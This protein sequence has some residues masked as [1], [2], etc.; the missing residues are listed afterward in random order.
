MMHNLRIRQEHINS[1]TPPFGVKKMSSDMVD[2]LIIK[3]EI[4]IM[5]RRVLCKG[6]FEYKSTSGSCSCY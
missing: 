6:C 5:K 2:D 3:E 1:S 4:R